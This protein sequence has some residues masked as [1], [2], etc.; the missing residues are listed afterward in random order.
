MDE[1]GVVIYQWNMVI[2]NSYI[3]VKL[4]ERHA[5][6]VCVSENGRNYTPKS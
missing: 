3:Y 2:F 1:H 4:P 6:D 5:D